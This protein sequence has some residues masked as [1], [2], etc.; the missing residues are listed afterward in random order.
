[1]MKNKFSSPAAYSLLEIIF[2]VL[3][4]S[5]IG[6]GLIQI[7]N[8]SWSSYN[9]S[10]AQ[11]ELQQNETALQQIANKARNALDISINSKGTQMILK[12]TTANEQLNYSRY[13]LKN[14]NLYLQNSSKQLRFITDWSAFNNWDK[15]IIGKGL[16]KNQQIFSFTTNNLLLIQ[17]QF[18]KNLDLKNKKEIKIEHQLTRKVYPRNSSVDLYLIEGSEG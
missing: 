14:N 16:I 17:L 12:E 10:K 15:T 7:K 3:I 18:K 11:S 1:M 4:F 6:L 5:I 2:V 13:I 9:Y 8:F